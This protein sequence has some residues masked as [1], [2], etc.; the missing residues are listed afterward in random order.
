MAIGKRKLGSVSDKVFQDRKQVGWDHQISNSSSTKKTLSSKEKEKH[1]RREFIQIPTTRSVSEDEEDQL[2]TGSESLR[3]K[4]SGSQDDML[5]SELEL[6]DGAKTFLEGI[7]LKGITRSRVDQVIENR[8]NRP[9]KVEASK[10]CKSLPKI[11]H[12]TDACSEDLENLDELDEDDF[13]L[14]S[15]SDDLDLLSNMSDSA[16]QS[17]LSE[18][19]SI[20]EDDGSELSDDDGFTDSSLENAYYASKRNK[21]SAATLDCD[22]LESNFAESKLPVR[23][24]DGT[25]QRFPIKKPEP[26]SRVVKFVEPEKDLEEERVQSSA[27]TTHKSVPSNSRDSSLGSRFG[28]RAL[29]EI[30]SPSSSIETR[31]TAAR[32]EIAE[33]SQEALADPEISLGLIKRLLAMCSATLKSPSEN[34]IRIDNSVRV[35]A[36]LSLLAV[37]LDI[38]PGYRIRPIS[39]V[40]K[41]N[42]VSQMVAVQREW[43]EGLVRVY[44]QYL[45]ICEKEIFTSSPLAAASLKSLCQLLQSKTH[46]NFSINIMEVLVRKLARKEWDQLSK[47]C[48]DSLVAVFRKDVRGDDS[49]RLVKFIGRTIK[50]KNYN[51]H[52]EL[53]ATL[54]SLRL[55]S[56]IS[57]TR[58]SID[59]VHS[60]KAQGQKQRGKLPWKD[61]TKRGKKNSEVVISKKAKKAMKETSAIEK[62]IQEAEE[63]VKEEEKQR[64]HTETLKLIFGLYF[65]IIKLPYCSRLLPTAL[66]GISNFALL[67]NIDFFRDLLNVLRQQ[68]KGTANGQPVEA[69]V[70]QMTSDNQVLNR[71]HYR[72][73]LLC[74][75]TAF[76]LLSGQGEALNLDLTDFVNELYGILIPICTLIEVD[77][78]HMIDHNLPSPTSNPIRSSSNITSS[79]IDLILKALNLIF[80]AN[81]LTIPPIRAQAFAKR[82]LSIS[83]NLPA[84]SVLKVLRFLEKLFVRQPAIGSVLSLSNGDLSSFERVSNG[85][86]RDELDDVDLSNSNCTIGWELFLLEKHW[87]YRVK[88]SV[89]KL[90]LAVGDSN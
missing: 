37:F 66:E 78:E 46:F 33:L 75:I 13:A 3:S 25:I 32:V 80:L 41:Q 56:E 86:H 81:R 10:S 88:E 42:K 23:M 59:Q 89:N 82:L 31:V 57:G 26:T 73:K 12:R 61:R 48:Y 62:E 45:E 4:L 85:I 24:A 27:P 38:I 17:D 6:G 21:Q 35:M 22:H 87:D 83:I 5:D 30:L 84:T 71:G 11:S 19:S 43:E 8:K 2:M 76:E 60:G 53:L 15:G 63:S 9:K 70:E 39:E 14:G 7:D 29:F 64:N 55:K 47:E 79:T 67:V 54:L 36:I 18:F 40:E 1:R 74:I 34:E 50:S 49:L 28:R 69:E 68:I 20:Q 90:V 51:V 72:D 44:R 16:S 58:A 65:R 52:P 77:N